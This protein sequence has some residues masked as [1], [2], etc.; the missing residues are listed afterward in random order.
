MNKVLKY[1][2]LLFFLCCLAS[3]RKEVGDSIDTQ[4]PLLFQATASDV[5]SVTKA[6]AGSDIEKTDQEKLI[7]LP[8][9]VFGVWTDLEESSDGNIVF[10]ESS[11]QK[12][13]YNSEKYPP[14]WEYEPLQYWKLNKFYRFRAYHPFEGESF[15]L[16]S[17]TSSADNI[18]IE[19]KIIPGNDDLL[20]GFW[21]DQATIDVIQNPVVFNFQHA[22][23]GLQFKIALKNVPEIA[24]TDE[25]TVTEFH[26]EGL[27]PTGT[28][29]YSHDKSDLHIPTLNWSTSFYDSKSF[30]EWTGSKTFQKFD[31]SYAVDIF[32]G[33]D[34]MVFC[35]PQTCSSSLGPTTV[36]FKT[37][38]SGD[39]D[40][41][42][43]LPSITWEPGKIYT[44]ILL[45]NKSDLE[46]KV[47][48]K[49]WTEI[50]SSVDVYL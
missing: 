9:G 12:V 46:I 33:E 4:V 18:V 13:N 22:L 26:I 11:A 49:D 10:M 29:S 41:S 3:C 20:V 21:S 35:I 40:N 23:C 30:F 5:V 37:A 17:S 7:T 44:Y 25:D 32:D 24:D 8:F 34:N 28:L 47:S 2:I 31:G 36:H 6:P 16:V 50:Q 39:A 43:T 27:I 15:S 1:N 48:I 45:V 42:A 38:G 14:A 19:Y